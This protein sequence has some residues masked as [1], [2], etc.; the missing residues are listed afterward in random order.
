MRISFRLTSETLSESPGKAKPQHPQLDLIRRPI[1]ALRPPESTS[2]KRLVPEFE[3]K[4]NE[5][6]KK[7]KAKVV[8]EVKKFEKKANESQKRKRRPRDNHN[9]AT[10]EDYSRILDSLQD[11]DFIDRQNAQRKK[12]E[13]PTSVVGLSWMM[14]TRL[15]DD[16]GDHDYDSDIDLSPPTVMQKHEKETIPHFGHG[17]WSA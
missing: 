3:K 13:A 14:M 15:S 16:E 7:K 1:W 4:A 8:G 2:A 12:S 5:S 10:K 6:Q 9:K 11:D 17:G